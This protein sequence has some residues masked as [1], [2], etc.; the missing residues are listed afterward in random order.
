MTSSTRLIDVIPKR[1]SFNLRNI[2]VYTQPNSAL[3]PRGDGVIA[4][5]K[6]YCNFVRIANIL[7]CNS[8]HNQFSRCI[9]NSAVGVDDLIDPPDLMSF[10]KGT[11]LICAIFMFTHNPIP[12][13]C[14]GA[15]GSS[16]PTSLIVILCASQIF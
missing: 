10:P 11:V 5:Y 6:P 8:A 9:Y 15:M 3:L 2:Y 12:L 14:R 16:P 4:P 1:H 13:S 7:I